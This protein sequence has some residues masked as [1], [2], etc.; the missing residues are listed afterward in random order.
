[1][2][3]LILSPVILLLLA[4]SHPHCLIPLHSYTAFCLPLPHCIT[5]LTVSPPHCI[6]PSLY[7]PLTV[8]PPHCITLSLYQPLTVSTFHLLLRG[9]NNSTISGSQQDYLAE[10]FG[11]PQRY[12]VVRKWPSF[13]HNYMTNTKFEKKIKHFVVVH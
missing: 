1:M 5:P 12:L 4:V 2:S 6:T 8:S 11:S 3:P 9:R 13:K 7:H 10:K